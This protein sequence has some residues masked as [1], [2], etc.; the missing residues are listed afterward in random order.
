MKKELDTINVKINSIR[1]RDDYIGEEGLGEVNKLEYHL[2]E[3]RALYSLRKRA[4]F[5]L[6]D[7]FTE[8]YKEDEDTFK[9]KAGLDADDFNDIEI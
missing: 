4:C 1:K 6:I 5:D 7:V 3:L 9:A 2:N 8:L